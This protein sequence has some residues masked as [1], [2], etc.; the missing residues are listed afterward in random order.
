[1]FEANL[2]M[3]DVRAFKILFTFMIIS[4]SVYAQETVDSLFSH[5]R[6]LDLNKKLYSALDELDF[7]LELKNL[8][9][10]LIL[11]NDPNLKWLWTSYA[12][13]NSG[14]ESVFA[15]SNFDNITLPL[16]QKFLADSRIDPIRYVLGVAEVGAVGYLAYRHIK[17]YGFLK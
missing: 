15:E 12:I 2:N 14:Q 9:K 10:S 17:K 5:Q 11:N 16:Y 7:Y 1:M 8:D 13:S 6:S 4:V 3:I